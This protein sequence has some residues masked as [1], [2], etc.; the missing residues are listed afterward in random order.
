MSSNNNSIGNVGAVTLASFTGVF[1]TGPLMYV[2]HPPQT[3]PYDYS[4]IRACKE[5][6]FGLGGSGAGLSVTMYF[7]TDVPTAQNISANPVWFQCPGPSTDPA[8]AWH[9][10]MQNADGL[11]ALEFKGKA[12]ALRA[13]AT[14]TVPGV[15]ATGVTNLLMLAAF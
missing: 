8:A 5:F 9:N 12:I 3:Q 10:P 13:V 11:N 14:L 4:L 2:V 7:T 1:D 15:A 6:M